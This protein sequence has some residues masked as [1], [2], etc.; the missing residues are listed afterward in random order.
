MQVMYVSITI[1]SKS[2][3]VEQKSFV[4]LILYA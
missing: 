3:N 4:K 1:A 2:F